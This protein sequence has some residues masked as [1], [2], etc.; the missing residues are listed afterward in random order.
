MAM[1]IPS[2]NISPTEP[3]YRDYAGMKARTTSK[4]DTE[5][6][7][8]ITQQTASPVSDDK[9]TA[10]TTHK[11]VKEKEEV[12]KEIN[13][14]NEKLEGMNRTIRFTIDEDS[15]EVIVRVVDKIS[16]EVISQIP[17]EEIVRLKERIDEMA[18]LLVEKTV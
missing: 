13:S 6:S 5:R 16:G 9:K 2:T 8:D 7:R 3:A 10:D 11:L 14:I 15:K 18:G 17:P 4:I 1:K 12:E